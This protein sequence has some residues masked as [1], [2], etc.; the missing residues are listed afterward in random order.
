MQHI[1]VDCTQ[2]EVQRNNCKLKSTVSEILGP[3][4]I[5]EMKLIKFLK[6]T[7]LLEEL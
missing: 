1:L 3:S 7:E 6:E 4:E 2:Y 5:E